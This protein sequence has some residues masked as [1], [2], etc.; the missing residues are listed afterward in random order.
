[1]KKLHIPSHNEYQTIIKLIEKPRLYWEHQQG[2]EICTDY[3][4]AIL[5][6]KL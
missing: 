1:M 3:L 4:A 6:T 5:K 2:I